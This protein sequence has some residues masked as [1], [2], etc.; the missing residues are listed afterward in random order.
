ME[1]Q[2]QQISNFRDRMTRLEADVHD[3]K[4]SYYDRIIEYI[5]KQVV[6]TYDDF[7]K[8]LATKAEVHMMETVVP[9]R[10]EDSYRFLTNSIADIKSDLNRKAT[11]DDIHL[12]ASTKVSLSLESC[13]M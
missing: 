1:Q 8:K 10:L 2:S 11:K 12:L 6:R 13:C 7:D 4:G 5:D 9:Q 3:M